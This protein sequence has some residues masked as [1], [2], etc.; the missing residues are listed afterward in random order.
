MNT[1]NILIEDYNNS[2][3]SDEEKYEVMYY[4]AMCYVS[5]NN[6]QKAKSILEIVRD[7]SNNYSTNYAKYD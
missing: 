5:L 7:N 4:Q 6:N 1:K 2:D 3:S